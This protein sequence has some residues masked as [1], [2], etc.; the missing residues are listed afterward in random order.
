MPSVHSLVGL[1]P[2]EP[3][4]IG[5]RPPL[6][7]PLR[8]PLVKTLSLLE[9]TS[10]LLFTMAQALCPI[11]RRTTEMK[12]RL[13]VNL[14]RF[15]WRFYLFNCYHGSIQAMDPCHPVPVSRVD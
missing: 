9:V 8:L 6:W 3:R 12:E 11:N 14:L 5:N 2:S 7:A 13:Y 15:R 1:P 10:L 4:D